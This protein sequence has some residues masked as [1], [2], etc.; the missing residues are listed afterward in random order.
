MIC[1]N[2]AFTLLSTF[3]AVDPNRV[4]I[5]V[6]ETAEDHTLIVPFYGRYRVRR[7]E[8]TLKSCVGY[9]RFHA[10]RSSDLRR[11]ATILDG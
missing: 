4:P 1:Y 11:N 9:A 10:V 2:G 5:I 6:E 8:A 7:L 3:I